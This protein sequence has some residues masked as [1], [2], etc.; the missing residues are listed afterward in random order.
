[1]YTSVSTAE[2]KNRITRIAD[3]LSRRDFIYLV[4]ILS[5]FGHLDWFLILAGIGSPI[6]F[7]TL[8]WLYMKE[9]RTVSY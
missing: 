4:V 7:M 3:F 5:L 9:K 6:F 2:E 1:M 8:I